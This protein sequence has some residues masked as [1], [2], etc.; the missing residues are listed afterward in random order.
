MRG[1]AGPCGLCAE[2]F[3]AV[4]IQVGWGLN[5]P[6]AGGT[7]VLCGL[8]RSKALGVALSLQRGQKA[9]SVTRF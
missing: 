4:L 6:S 8:V 2:E 9:W 7:I 3:D 5:P 1:R